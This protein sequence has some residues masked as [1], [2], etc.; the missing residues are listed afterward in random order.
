MWF[1]NES[2]H[3]VPKSEFEREFSETTQKSGTYN[4]SSGILKINRHMK[5]GG[6]VITK[7]R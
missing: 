7:S 6:I 3:F 1:S 5:L 2:S 4:C